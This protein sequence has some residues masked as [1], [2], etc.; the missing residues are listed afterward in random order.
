MQHCSDLSPQQTRTIKPKAD[1][2]PAHGRVLF[3][4]QTQV[5]QNFITAN[6]KRA[7]GNWLVTSCIQH[8][9]IQCVLFLHSWESRSHHKLQ[10]STEKP[11]AIS[12]SIFHAWQINQQTSI[13]LKLN[14]HTVFGNGWFIPKLAINFLTL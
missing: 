5:R 2:T 9:G 14:V 4:R 10:L 7:E 1:R 8:L 12:A 3:L 11:N 13:Q 6:I